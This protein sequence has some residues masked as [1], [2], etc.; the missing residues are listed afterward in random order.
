MKF[1]IEFLVLF[2]AESIIGDIIKK[3]FSLLYKLGIILIKIFTLSR[4]TL[5]ELEMKYKDS[6]LPYIIIYLIIPTLIYMIT[7]SY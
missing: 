6:P 1:I 2:L 5:P 3:I 4:K 7:K